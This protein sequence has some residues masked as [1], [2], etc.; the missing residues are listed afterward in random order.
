MNFKVILFLLAVVVLFL[1]V[2]GAKVKNKNMQKLVKCSVPLV[3]FVALMLCMSKN[4]EPY[5]EYDVGVFTDYSSLQPTSQTTV[6]NASPL[7]D[8][9]GTLVDKMGFGTSTGPAGWA[10]SECESNSA[11]YGPSAAANA[12]SAGS[13]FTNID[14]TSQPTADTTSTCWNACEQFAQR[15][16]TGDRLN[17]YEMGTS[18]VACIEALNGD[19]SNWTNWADDEMKEM[20]AAYITG[21]PGNRVIARSDRSMGQ[22]ML[23]TICSNMDGVITDG[24]EISN[25]D[26]VLSGNKD[27][28]FSCANLSRAFETAV[29]EAASKE[30][31]MNP[32]ATNYNPNATT[33]D[34]SCIMPISGC[35]DQTATNHNPLATTDDGSCTYGGGAATNTRIEIEL[36]DHL[37]PDGNNIQ[38]SLMSTR[39]PT[40]SR[41]VF[42]PRIRSQ[43]QADGSAGNMAVIPANAQGGGGGR[44]ESVKIFRVYVRLQADHEDI[45][46]VGAKLGGS[47]TMPLKLPAIALPVMDNDSY[48]PT[49]PKYTSF[50]KILNTDTG[51]VFPDGYTPPP[52]EE[53]VCIQYPT[54]LGITGAGQ[55][56]PPPTMTSTWTKES[57]ENRGNSWEAYEEL[58]TLAEHWLKRNYMGDPEFGSCVNMGAT[59]SPPR[60]FGAV[61]LDSSGQPVYTEEACA[62][63]STCSLASN[64]GSTGQGQCEWT[65]PGYPG[66][67]FLPSSTGGPDWSSIDDTPTGSRHTSSDFY[68]DTGHSLYLHPFHTSTTGGNMRATGNTGDAT[69]RRVLIAQLALDVDEINAGGACPDI[70]FVVWG[71]LTAA[72][73]AAAAASGTGTGSDQ[74]EAELR[75]SPMEMVGDPDTDSSSTTSGRTGSTRTGEWCQSAFP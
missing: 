4:V 73:A 68:D 21:T 53:S 15:A 55:I 2:T 29:Q 8:A 17:N 30:G 45:W 7:I 40:Q 36:V 10:G 58:D 6:N 48:P 69:D 42:A 72:A 22:D 37:V 63:I 25:S 9:S 34:T 18:A 12:R 62:N 65:G 71:N 1:C 23:L 32:T 3:L 35:T 11:S 24:S 33:D 39:D 38:G 47:S 57:C 26:C 19:D 13:V 51:T 44:P 14:A 5:C 16:T 56:A 75:L 70:Q 61:E 28:P 50:L 74:W 43:V 59:P 41:I 60:T 46:Y 52:Q 54:S 27:D 31:C 49:D 20:M 67:T 64:P 66:G